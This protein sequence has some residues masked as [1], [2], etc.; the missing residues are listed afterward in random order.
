M[1]APEE[2]PPGRFREA[3]EGQKPR[4][5]R[6]V[7]PEAQEHQEAQP[8]HLRREHFVTQQERDERIEGEYALIDDEFDHQRAGGGANGTPDFT[9]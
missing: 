6:G 8:A 4:D 3:A 7:H 1:N 5:D 2:K 9:R